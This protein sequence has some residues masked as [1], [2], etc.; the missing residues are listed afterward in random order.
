MV[1]KAISCL[2]E[3]I[4]QTIKSIKGIYIYVYIC[5]LYIVYIYI[6]YSLY[7][8]YMDIEKNIMQKGLIN[9]ILC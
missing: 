2:L 7:C 5:I 3:R 1:L 8:I 9:I 4:K 6:L